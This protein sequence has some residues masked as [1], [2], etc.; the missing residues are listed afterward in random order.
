MIN[1]LGFFA[2]G[3]LFLQDVEAANIIFFISYLYGGFFLV[4]KASG[5]VEA[6]VSTMRKKLANREV[7]DS[8]YHAVSFCAWRN[9][10]MEW[11]SKLLV[12]VPFI[13]R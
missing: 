7:N 8:Y 2:Y 11:R 13:F 1:A 6:L 5:T 9:H 4:F 10:L 12:Y 3:K